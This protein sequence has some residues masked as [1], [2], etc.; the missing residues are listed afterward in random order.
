[1]ANLA[2]ILHRLGKID[3]SRETFLRLQAI[4]ERLD[5]TAPP[6]ARLANLARELGM[7]ADWR[8]PAATPSDIGPRPPLDTLGPLRWDPAP[9]PSWRLAEADGGTLALEQY[10]GKPLVVMFYLGAS[11]PHCVEQLKE[12]SSKAK[13]FS[14]AGIALV[15]I[16]RESQDE[17]KT[18]AVELNKPAPL[19]IAL[20]CDPTL[21]T[22]KSYRAFDDFENAPLHG[23]FLV[24]GQGQIRWQDVSFEP[25]KNTAFLIAEGRRLLRLP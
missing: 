19:G 17:L 25:F 3:E 1:L 20:A 2:D 23:T 5:L 4:S 8:R 12:F 24:D 22:F 7:Q 13:Q 14:D 21:E 16:S 9:A 10:H 6:F 11:C 15:G 18:S